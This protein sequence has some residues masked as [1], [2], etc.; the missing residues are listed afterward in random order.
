MTIDVVGGVK[1]CSSGGVPKRN[2]KVM[3]FN[4]KESDTAP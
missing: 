2:K 1:K 4:M 3:Y